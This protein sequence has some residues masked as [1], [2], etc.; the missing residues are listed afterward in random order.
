MWLRTVPGAK[1]TKIYVGLVTALASLRV[2]RIALISSPS[3]LVYLYAFK[4][5]DLF[6]LDAL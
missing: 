5:W 1:G 3:Q 2:S 6:F 4:H